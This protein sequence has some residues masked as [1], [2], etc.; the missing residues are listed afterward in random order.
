VFTKK[1]EQF[2]KDLSY[3]RKMWLTIDNLSEAHRSIA[4]Q[5]GAE[6]VVLNCN[7]ITVECVEALRIPILNALFQAGAAIREFGLHEPSLQQIYDQ[8]LSGECSPNEVADTRP[9]L[10][11]EN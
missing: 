1:I 6:K 10:R 4:L 9:A 11:I 5:S 2:S 3:S 8:S 7:T